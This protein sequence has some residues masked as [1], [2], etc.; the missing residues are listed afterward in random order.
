M[1]LPFAL[2]SPLPAAFA[3]ALWWILRRR[4]R[5]AALVAG[6]ALWCG[7][8]LFVKQWM[9]MEE[10][11]AGPVAGAFWL[12]AL[13]AVTPA[14]VGVIMLSRRLRP[15]LLWLLALVGGMALLADVIYF[16]FFGDVIS[17]PALL[18]S[19][20]T[21]NV[22]GS[23]VSLIEARD[24]WFVVDL[25][26][27]LPLVRTVAG[28]RRPEDAPRRWVI[29][30]VAAVACVAGLLV[31][32]ERQSSKPAV[33]GVLGQVFTN[34]A[35]VQQ[36]GPFGYH[37]HD[38]WGYLRSRWLRPPLSSADRAEVE[39]WFAAR[40]PLRA[41]T[42]P[43]FGVARHRNLLV[44]QAESLQGFVVGMRVG[45]QEVTPNLN[46]WWNEG[47]AFS[48]VTDQT[49]EGRTSD[50]EFTA[51]V[52]LLPLEH[53]AAAFG[54]PSNR[55][56][57][58]PRVLGAHG[59]TTLSAVPFAPSFWNRRVIHPAYG[60]SRSL[61]ADAFEPG[62]MIGWGLNDHDFL[63]QMAPKLAN[64]PRPFFAW[65]ITLSLHHPFA[66]FPDSHKVMDVGEWTGK[67]FGNYIHTMRFLD[68][69]LGELRDALAKEGLA[70]D[71]VI[72][73]FGDHDAGFAWESPIARTAGFLPYVLDWYM[74]DRVPWL[75]LLPGA[76]APRGEMSMEAGQTDMAPTLLAL[77]GI[78]PA[79]FPW[80]GR[81][82]LGHPATGVLVRPHGGWVDGK[83][84]FDGETTN[85]ARR[86]Y[87]IAA[88][89]VLPLSACRQGTAEATL[90]R[91][92]SRRVLTYDLQ[93]SLVK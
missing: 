25:A 51:L 9:M 80:M 27:A 43:L 26:A 76:G 64:L 6:D 3:L 68:T 48:R 5:W 56:V 92:I 47:L 4:P 66:S 41:G 23:V 81:N 73:I 1:S 14:A 70:D 10:T 21:G 55:Y 49:S 28:A 57:G 37:L 46:R 2:L 52:S 34:L 22:L 12:A 79:P 16:R 13:L 54:Y 71:T 93:A 7:V 31:A 20:Q 45:G 50:A 77:M 63:R 72:A 29:R 17:A 88:H 65:L 42:G 84:F 87:D 59:Y 15:W 58:L 62:E 53:G 67:P 91:E 36:L 86:C 90:A 83:L 39:D 44:I 24:A 60:F 38:G 33:A 32:G 89:R 85:P 30:S 82:L 69:A 74:Q 40:K 11:H 75:V 18:A 8:S 61:F 35:I 19:G 78:D